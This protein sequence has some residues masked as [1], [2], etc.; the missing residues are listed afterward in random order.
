MRGPRESWYSISARALEPS[1][2]LGGDEQV[3]M[4]TRNIASIM[5]AKGI[6]VVMSGDL[7]FELL[8]IMVKL[9]VY[10]YAH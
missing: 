10:G 1:N 7:V 3:A 2:D 6:L 5:I 9:I 4:P 8:S